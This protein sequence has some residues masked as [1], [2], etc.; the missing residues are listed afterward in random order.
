[1]NSPPDD[2]DPLADYREASAR[3]AGRPSAATRKAIL[4][5]AA[6][7]ARARTPAANDSRYIWRGVA[8]VAVLGIG[9]MLWR[10]VDHRMPGEPAALAVQ[11][12]AEEEAAA[13]SVAPQSA[14]SAAS[15]SADANEAATSS[16]EQKA[17][18]RAPVVDAAAPLREQE[19]QEA[20]PASPAPPRAAVAP[21]PAQAP[22]TAARAEFSAT[23]LEAQA[24]ARDEAQAASRNA[25][26]SALTAERL[27][28]QA[29]RA[30]E[31]AE[32]E[33][34][35]KLH[36]AA[37]YASDRPHTVWLVRDG[38]GNILRSGELAA[39]ATLGDL[40]SDIERDLGAGRF[41]RPWRI[42]TLANARGQEIQLAIA[43][44]P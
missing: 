21:L 22:Q 23:A 8:G 7:A 1:M 33:A 28:K 15:A 30:E 36:F 12:L 35:L 18:A 44:T 5:N 43:Q 34:L 16:G 3:D 27:G 2:H 11:Q 9:L 6:A 31:G 26:T 32:A 17:Q 14:A 25:V 19:I 37:Q 13:E 42:H 10:Q 24:A 38:A 29:P 40:R 39:G 41:L 4:D 20:A